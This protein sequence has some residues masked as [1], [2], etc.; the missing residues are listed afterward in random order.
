MIAY[1]TGAHI[2]PRSAN[3]FFIFSLDDKTLGEKINSPQLLMK[4]GSK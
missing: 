3:W 1:T 2:L 4:P